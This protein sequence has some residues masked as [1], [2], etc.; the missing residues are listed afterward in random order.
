[1]D[2]KGGLL[3]IVI[4]YECIMIYFMEKGKYTAK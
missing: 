3:K 1:M 2:I 4:F